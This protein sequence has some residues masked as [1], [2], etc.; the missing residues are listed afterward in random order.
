VHAKSIVPLLPAFDRAGGT[1]VPL[2]EP[3]YGKRYLEVADAGAAKSILNDRKTYM[4]DVEMVRVLGCG[5]QVRPGTDLQL[6][7]R[8]VMFL[9]KNVCHL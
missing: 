6:Q 7:Y 5:P 2:Y 1:C 4:K 3:I 9:G 8:H